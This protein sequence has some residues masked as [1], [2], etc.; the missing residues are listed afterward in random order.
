MIGSLTYLVFCIRRD[1]FVSDAFL[2]RQVHEPMDRHLRNV[3]RV[4]RYV[5]GTAT[6][7]LL[8]PRSS[9]PSLESIRASADADWSRCK[10]TRRSSSG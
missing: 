3:K 2:S 7:V 1:I 6:V 5:E 10:E 4:L 9:E 8:Y